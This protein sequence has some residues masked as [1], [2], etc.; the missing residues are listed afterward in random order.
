M[1]SIPVARLNIIKKFNTIHNYTYKYPEINFESLNKIIPI[2]CPI[3]G[4]FK[5]LAYSHFKGHGCKKC[6][7]IKNSISKSHK[8]DDYIKKV[9]K[10]HNNFYTYEKVNYVSRHKKITVTCPIHGDFN[11]SANHHFYGKGCRTCYYEKLGLLFRFTK[12]KF[13]QKANIIHNNKYTYPG[14][15]VNSNTKLEIKCY[16]HGIFLQTPAGHLSGRGCHMCKESK[17]ESFISN[18]LLKNEIEFKKEFLIRGFNYR[19]DFYLPKYNLLI[20]YHGIQ[21]YKEVKHWGGKKALIK[22]RKRDIIKIELAKRHGYDIITIPYYN[23][24]NIINIKKIIVFNNKYKIKD[25][26]NEIIIFN[27]LFKNNN[28][29]KFYH[30]LS[31]YCNNDEKVFNLYYN[32]KPKIKH[33][34]KEFFN[35]VFFKIKDYYINKS[36][37]D[38]K[39]YLRKEHE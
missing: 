37:F 35:T 9:K 13:I 7:I 3:H 8:Q 22:N 23:K 19:Y 18:I 34:V 5:Q 28:D 16:K 39:I 2:I 38:N 30:L 20:E 36:T 25:I 6:G 32:H 17:G 4:E 15:Y 24:D 26:S 21:H 29:F 1:S 11:I 10:R 14:N 33:K 12:E 31:G 27:K